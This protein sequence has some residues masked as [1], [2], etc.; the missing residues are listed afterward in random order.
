IAPEA[1]YAHLARSGLR[2]GP[3]MRAV[4]ALYRG[5]GEVLTELALPD[6]AGAAHRLHPALVDGAMQAIA[7]LTLG[8]GGDEP[9]TFLGFGMREVR[10]YAPVL[11]G[12]CLAHVRLAGPLAADAESFR[13][14]VTLA[15]GAGRVCARFGE[16]ALKRFHDPARPRLW[17]VRWKAR[18]A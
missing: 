15:D 6:G 11:A 2:Y 12:P 1:L 8:F 16:V 5:D 10:L 14:D 4:A 7:G 13:V 3:A 17:A 18:P 9:A